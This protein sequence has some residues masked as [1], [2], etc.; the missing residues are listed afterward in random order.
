MGT[1]IKRCG[2]YARCSTGEQS[3][4]S[5]INSLKEF[6]AAR[7]WEVC[8]VYEDHAISGTKA[9][10]PGLDAMWADCR[11]RKIDICLVFALDR[12]ARSLKHL[13]EALDEFGR[14]EVDF[15]CLKQDIDTT[16]AASR[17]LFHIVG[18]VAEFERELICSR[19][20]AGMRAAR[21]KG[22]HIGRPPL[23]KF[24]PEQLTQICEMRAK[25]GASIRQ[26]SIQHGT[27]QWMVKKI[28]LG[29]AH[30]NGA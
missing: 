22:K 27:T 9:K 5:Q 14:L 6:A 18:A 23:R 16:S 25:Q 24:S 21:A 8:K 1:K 7:G 17:L 11:Q 15:V 30:A 26:L 10:R 13:I 2:I 4:D 29:T 28:L 3:T 12:L 19:V 20:R